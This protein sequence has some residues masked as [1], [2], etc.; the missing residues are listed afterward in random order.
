[1]THENSFPLTEIQEAF[2]VGRRLGAGVGTQVQLEFEVTDLDV[3]RLEEAWNRLV[4]DTEML[5]VTVGQDGT[6]SIA[7]EVPRYR[8]GVT[9]LSAS[10]DPAGELERLR[11]G[12]S[13]AGFDPS[14]WPLFAIRV[15]LLGGG[16][17][18]VFF[19]VDELVADGPSV[20]LL[21]QQWNAVYD[22]DTS[23]TAPAITFQDY[24][25]A[26]AVPPQRLEKALQYWRDK[27]STAQ[28]D[29][30][31]P[32]TT[33]PDGDDR[34]RRRLS[35]TFDEAE[36]TGIKQVA[37]AAKATPSAL[38]L[39][40]YTAALGEARP[41]VLTTYNRTPVH[42]DVAR[43]VGPFISTA[44]FLAPEEKGT[45]GE[46][47]H[48]VQ[49]QLWSD[50]ENSAV[51][52]VRAHRE[53]VRQDRGRTGRAVPVVFT[54]LL[55][56]LTQGAG[57]WAARVDD[58]STI[59]HTPGVH[60][61]QC[62]QPGKDGGLVLSWDI[63]IGV[64]D[65]ARTEQAFRQLADV[66]RRI[67][68][69]GAATLE[70]ATQALFEDEDVTGLPLTEVQSAY[71]VGRA[72]DLA[73]TAETRVYQEFRL[74]G[75][76][77]DRLEQA[78]R[79]LT[80]HHP[81]LRGTV[82]PDGTLSIRAQVP[83][84][85]IVRH[86]LTGCSVGETDRRLAE[87][88]Q[89]MRDTPFGLGGFPMYALEASLLPGGDVVLH[90]ALDALLA[91]AQSFALLFGQLFALS[92]G[93]TDVLGSEAGGLAEYLR[94]VAARS[95]SAEGEAAGARWAGKF[96][97]LPS[98][99]PIADSGERTHRRFDMD[100]TALRKRAEEIGVPADML[101][102]TAYTDA[103]REEFTEPFTTVV[104]S[105]DRP[106]GT[107]Q[108][109]GDFTGLAWLVVD[110]TL[111]TRFDDRAREIW[112]RVKADLECG[113]ARS[114]LGQ[115]RQRV[116]RSKGA[117]RL[118][119]VFT[120]VPDVPADLHSDAVEIRVS[121]SQ[122]AQVGLDNVPL[123]VGDTVVCQWDAA[124]DALPAS[125]LDELFASY[126]NRLRSLVGAPKWTI[127]E[128]LEESF[129]RNAA[130]PAIRWNGET[131]SYAELDR[132]SAQLARHL[133]RHGCQVGDHVAVH[134][135]RSADLV[136][137]LVAVVRA[138]G[139]YVPVD[140]VN[141]ADRVRY[142]VEDSGAR[143]MIADGARAEVAA[144]AH[145]ICPDRD[146]ALLAEEEATAPG[147]EVTP[148]D[149]IYM[150]YTSGSTGLPK[151]CPNSHRGVTNRL[152]WMQK[153]FPLTAEDRVL[154]KTPYG[155][156]VSA[157]EF[158]WPLMVGASIVV[159]RPGGHVD[160]SYLAG[161][162]R[163]ESVTITHFVPSVLGMFLREPSASRC[164]SLRYVFASGEALPLGTM[165]SFFD[166]LGG[167]ELHN[168]YGPTEAA[169]DVTHWP[170]RK[171]WDEPTVPIGHAIDNIGIHIVDSSLRE[172]PPGEQGEICISGYGVAL[173]YHNRPELT[174]ERFVST[175][176]ATRLYRTG[177]LG[178]VAP[179]GEIRYL[180]RIDNQFKL[181]GLRIEPEEI[182]AALVSRGGLADARV[183][184]VTGED[185]EPNLA[186][187][188]VASGAAPSVS[189]LR[190]ALKD[191]LPSYMVPNLYR[192]V[193]ALPLTPNGKLDRKVATSLFR[194]E[195]ASGD[196]LATVAGI[197]ASALNVS[198][199]AP[200]AD[201]FDLGA[202]SF[203]AIRI[204]QE[205][206][207]VT[208]AS[209]PVDALIDTPTVAGLVAVLGGVAA[210]REEQGFDAAVIAKVAAELLG[211]EEIG[212]DADLFDLGATSFTMIRLAQA[213]SERHGADVP[214]DVLID[215]PT[216]RGIAAGL[217]AAPEKQQPKSAD[218]RIAFDPEAKK[219]FKEAKI[220]E[221]RIAD[222]VP[223][224]P[225]TSPAPLDLF[226][227]SSFRDFTAEPL[228][229]KALLD[230]VALTVSGEVDGRV[231][232]RYP[233]AG[234]FYPVQ[235]YVYVRDDRVSGIDGG[236]YYVHPGERTLVRVDSRFSVTEQTQVQH[237]RALVGGAAF[238]IFL[239]STPAAIAPAYG[240]R[241]A[242]KYSGLEAGHISQLLMTAAP[243]HGL[244]MC[245]V[246]EMDFGSVRRHFQ[247]DDDQELLVSLW[248]GALGTDDTRR[249]A[250]LTS[251]ETTPEVRDTEPIAV[252][253]F[254]AKL[255]GA[256]SLAELDALLADGGT[257]IGPVPQQRWN[258]LRL[259]AKRA[260][261]TVG[262]YLDDVT[263]YEGDEFG[264]TEA[265]A[266]AIDP[267]ER[268]LLT[269]TR[270]C[271]EDAGVTKARLAGSGP[272]GVFVGAMW[273]DH[274]LYGV[275]SRAGGEAGTHATRG[276][277]AH[278]I[279]HAFD[280]TGPS[281]VL[282]SGCVSGLAAIDAGVKA[283]RS[284]QCT[285]AVAAASNLVLHPDHLD[286]LSELGLVAEETDS[287]AF[288][289]R[290][291]G[292][293]VGEGVG[294]VLLKPLSQALADGDPVHAVIRGGAVRHSG[295]TRQ[296]G[297]PSRKR[298]EETVRAALDDAGVSPDAV[299]YVEAAASGAA[300][301]DA[302]E[303]AGLGHVFTEPVV[304]GSVKPAVGHL[305]ASSVFAQL[306]K[307][308]CQFRAGRIHPTRL[309]SEPNPNVLS[310]PSVELAR[311]AVE[312]QPLPDADGELKKRALINGFAGTGSYGC[313]VI[314]EPPVFTQPQDD[315]EHLL[316]LSADTPA[317]LAA[318]A[319]SLAGVID[320]LP[321]AS[322]VRTLREGRVTREER[323]VVVATR[324]NAAER[325]RQL[326]EAIRGG[327]R[328][329][330][331]ASP[332]ARWW[333]DGNEADWPVAP[334]VRRVSLP[335]TPLRL[336]GK[337]VAAPE[338]DVSVALDRLVQIV[339]A[340][341]GI[342]ETSL[343]PD[344]DLLAL[345]VTSRQ[346]QRI[347]ARVTAAGGGHLPLETL[348]ETD[349][350]ADLAVAAFGGNQ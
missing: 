290:A 4:R 176:Y 154:Q 214:V 135:D 20:S 143:L 10:E 338:P 207:R 45:L 285:S 102:L 295:T 234:G 43:L 182:E 39:A 108:I 191:V 164:T 226:D 299:G 1:M 168:L 345:G 310:V 156:D 328:V 247:L 84:Y 301:A 72:G 298:Q 334:G 73:G 82:Q 325:L 272:V 14:V 227:A 54:S 140:P 259:N 101:L 211:I 269:T 327:D 128:H 35:V 223:R 139:V 275:T 329:V 314:E 29:L 307:V 288:T 174:A 267:Q 25:K 150:I 9:D 115:L 200:D 300:L 277:L 77:V 196:L 244:G 241:L 294:A 122:T 240:E 178:M 165:K 107:S 141:P 61:E 189:A 76:D 38:L 123:L 273:A 183:L 253:G 124:A 276:S 57:G 134:M 341:T 67:A 197:V 251:G 282:D 212:L 167:S 215:S 245:P 342:A 180:G 118:P 187:I 44:I 51:S 270:W 48:A 231:K 243:A 205:I 63:A 85:E 37:S 27:L 201:L 53:W 129:A 287:C 233:S 313:L 232:R 59:T 79:T 12:T 120:R 281:V 99:P 23:V 344:A 155:F 308:I 26:T 216:P 130:L 283:I 236:L 97:T 22:G 179:D 195:P 153:A 175:P 319:E 348:F 235:V 266:A 94:G 7:A 96:A 98:G 144:G 60:I 114:G 184:P 55:G 318:L 138:G 333:L 19:A 208:G 65:E 166:V 70:V 230:L 32:F 132:R 41:V 193:D 188:C 157:W 206:E 149:P 309:T 161:L 185:D 312:W 86:D 151:G 49:S 131:I 172:V 148:D 145:V 92:A 36:W 186:A 326:S 213:L 237:N 40:L 322:V 304:V 93:R 246:G 320:D 83:P 50:L 91:D 293:I 296:F 81:A 75:H 278:R 349:N 250:A 238:A 126:E 271:L 62:V 127:T 110:D 210:P 332:Q 74:R 289:D 142:L 194:T 316:P 146:A 254:A 17:A 71:L 219:A 339:R 31:A 162:I 100:W 89:R 52:G 136:V 311:S 21:L 64:L 104:V 5:R 198:A 340:E 160:T 337:A 88:A 181:R 258:P 302:L 249:R 121:Q 58:S 30:A 46:R 24:V 169:I 331:E 3:A 239:V 42:A 274:A 248:G 47:T 303:V 350:I 315:E 112:A 103:L 228:P 34:A 18:R 116:F 33:D 286:V 204:A 336:R 242:V 218:I 284:G 280:L 343:P 170:C 90:A 95:N 297:L 56:S 221:R 203:T 292:W 69:E 13:G 111:P 321:L 16:R 177:D 347:A 279:S 66:L 171:D 268:L 80:S 291:S 220:S 190:Q 209:V 323:A 262:G 152:V 224:L 137:A 202:T 2:Y 257:A 163:A 158:F 252:I 261:A 263:S 229:A 173:G 225:L 6:Q 324:A 317:N 260:G 8:V 222:D 119:L 105:W 159:A 192:F 106:A 78:W 68:R 306:G 109:I 117:L 147:V 87:V 11:H 265:E 264:I 15:A 255:P 133:I 199:V 125:R 335:P 256:D 330:G 305:E 217:G 113:A 346:L 28:L